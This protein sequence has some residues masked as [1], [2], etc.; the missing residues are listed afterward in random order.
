LYLWVNK[1]KVEDE[2]CRPTLDGESENG[3]LV[4]SEV[5]ARRIKKPM[6][7][8]N[9]GLEHKPTRLNMSTLTDLL[10]T[11]RRKKRSCKISSTP[12]KLIYPR[13]T[14]RYK[15]EKIS[16]FHLRQS[17]IHLGPLLLGF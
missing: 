1:A 17:L 11:E 3:T 14:K 2:M 10:E 5:I 13:L 4:L 12:R 16:R 8:Q 7:L 9:V 15:K 6:I